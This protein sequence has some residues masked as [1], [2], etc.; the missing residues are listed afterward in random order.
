[1]GRESAL[2]QLRTLLGEGSRTA[3]VLGI[4]GEGK[5]AVLATASRAA[6]ADGDI[7]LSITGRATDR[8][9]PYAALVD[10]LSLPAAGGTSDPL[11]DRLLSLDDEEHPPDALRLRLDLVEWLDQLADGRSVL[12][13]VDDVHWVDPSSRSVLAFVANRLAALPVSLVVAARGSAPE[14]FESHPRLALEPLGKRAAGSLLRRAGYSLN[15]F[16]RESVLERAAGNPLALLELGRV[17]Q[18]PGAAA[19]GAVNEV[20]ST[21][22]AAFAADLSDLPERTRRMLLLAAAG[23]DDLGVLVRVDRRRPADQPPLLDALAPAEAKGL[24]RVIE[25]WVRFR[26]PLARSAVYSSA[27]AAQRVDAHR[28]LADALDDDTDRRVRHRAAAAVAPD[29]DVAAALVEVAERAKARGA[30][31]EAARLTV[32]A[33]DLTPDP[34]VRAGRMLDAIA[35]TLPTGNLAWLEDLATRLRSETDDPRVRARASHFRAYALAQTHQ[36]DAARAALTEALEALVDVDIDHGWG[37]LTTLAVLVYQSG[38]GVETLREWYQR[39]LRQAP[40]SPYPESLLIEAA[41]AWIRMV[42]DPLDRPPDLLRLV[43]DDHTG[44]SNLPPE[45]VTAREM[46]IGAAAWLLEETA[47]ANRHLRRAADLMQISHINAQLSQTLRALAQVQ[48]DAADLDGAD[49]TARMLADLGEAEA[50][51]LDRDAGLAIRSRVAAVRGDVEAAKSLAEEVLFELEIGQFRVLEAGMRQ[52]YGYLHFS[53]HDMDGCY[54]QL[55][56]LFH[57]DGTPLH[58]HVSYRAL[59]DLVAAAVRTG[60]ADEM[61]PLMA[62][63]SRRLRT[64]GTRHRLALARARALLAGDEA[65]EFHVLATGDAQASQWPFDLANARLEYGVWLRRRHR[66]TDARAYLQAAADVFD[67][68]G[69]RAWSELAHTELRAAGVTPTTDPGTRSWDHLTAQEREVVRLAATGMTN[70]EIGASLYLS[71]RTVGAHL[72]NAFPKLGVTSRAQLRD[73][74]EAREPH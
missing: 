50:I 59:A 47:A 29:E 74:V 19:F 54:H 21:V 72:Y 16:V 70:R 69:A 27:T 7:V 26:H 60:R 17:A 61:T 64:P 57:N 39:Y 65:E 46:M 48:F 13:V 55:R 41:Q 1:M 56:S 9:L 20:P 8:D 38:S 62:E 31:D 6:A 44:E 18:A 71:P 45:L 63:A 34:S 10:L 3:V 2:T 12:V 22:E 43:H 52:T 28:Q 68:L 14:G 23:G 67:R 53:E 49:R 25:G 40:D 5:T 11:L 36:Q 4:P 30:F 42:M 51:A 66:P 33:A 58:E 24:I 37:S 15:A 73:I 35:T 32:R